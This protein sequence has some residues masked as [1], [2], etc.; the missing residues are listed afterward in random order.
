MQRAFKLGFFLLNP[1]IVST[2]VADTTL[3]ANSQTQ[4]WGPTISFQGQLTTN[5]SI[6]KS[7]KKHKGKLPYLKKLAR[8]AVE[9]RSEYTRQ[10]KMGNTAQGKEHHQSIESPETQSEGEALVEGLK[11]ASASN[12]DRMNFASSAITSASS[13]SASSSAISYSGSHSRI[14]KP[15]S[16]FSTIRKPVENNEGIETS[17]GEG[18][19][20]TSGS[21]RSRGIGDKSKRTSKRRGYRGSFD[22]SI[23]S[24]KRIKSS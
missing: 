17:S 19:L 21:P 8:N 22:L 15:D 10:K 6:A 13:A 23:I 7:L 18:T 20:E 11:S 24:S 1:P 5:G 2:R 3:Q 4:S 14:P 12:E 9:L 16:S